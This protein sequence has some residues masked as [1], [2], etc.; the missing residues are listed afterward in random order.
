MSESVNGIGSFTE[1]ACFWDTLIIN[2]HLA[3]CKRL[4]AIVTLSQSES[5]NSVVYAGFSRSFENET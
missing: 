4:G 1:W 5:S 3:E 2:P